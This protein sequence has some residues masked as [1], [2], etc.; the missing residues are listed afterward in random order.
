MS[1]PSSISTADGYQLSAW[2]VGS[3]RPGV[4]VPNGGYYA[5]VLAAAIGDSALV[6]DLRNRG[7]SSTVT[8]PA[9]LAAG[10]DRDLAD[11]D[12]VRVAAGRD[13]MTLIGHSYVGEL[14]LR[15]AVAHPERVE[16]VVAL[17]PSGYAVGHPGPPPPDEVAVDIFARLAE[18]MRTPAGDDPVARCEA[19]WAILAP[20]YVVDPGLAPRVQAWGRC[21][22]A[23]ERTFLGYWLRYVEPSLRARSVPADDLRRVECPVLLIHGRRDRS[24]PFAASEAWASRLPEARLLAVPDTAH[25]PWLEA[26][27][28]VLPAVHQFLAGEW[29]AAATRGGVA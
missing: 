12:A 4:V 17:G 6:Y 18:F 10:V 8:D 13:R 2:Q 25:A 14:V 29:P 5:A 22:H 15:Y 23:N 1:L 9:V 27:D 3:G 11:L 7:A 20:L 28:A 16:R 19:A 26:P 21:E 24:A